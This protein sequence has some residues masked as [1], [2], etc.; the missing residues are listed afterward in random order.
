MRSTDF[1]D[2]VSGRRRGVAAA[3]ARAA[4]AVAEGPYRAAVWWRNRRYDRRPD[5]VHACGVPVVSV[6]N[7]TLG[8]SGKTPMVKW[9]ARRLRAEGVRVALV[10]RGY[11]AEGGG[12]NDE[13]LELE[14]SLPDVP[15][16]QNR[17]RVEAARVA[18][19]ELAAQVVVMDDGFQHRRLARDLDLVLLD[20]TQPFGFGRVFPRGALREPVAGL[21]RAHAVCLT[22]AELVE[23]ATREAVRRRVERLAP[24]AVWCE[25]TTR[26]V[27]LVSAGGES[28]PLEGLRG[29][30]VA[31]FCGIGN[32][33]SFRRLL[34]GLGADVRA[35]LEF[36][37][38]H[39]YRRADVE[40]IERVAE[41]ADLVV[42]TQKDLVKVGVDELAGCPLRA[43]AIEAEL[44]VGEAGLSGLLGELARRAPTDPDEP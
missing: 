37:D 16:V 21:R 33:D 6:G 39:L 23:T 38:H 14:Q 41:G 42:C 12:P 40:R 17:D 2:L 10:S 7:L 36:P 32:P 30:G 11:G 4:L 28:E 43:V 5:L 8:G 20:A 27:A 35:L 24:A 19:E 34:A 26:P 29:G 31:A 44:A 15:H 22:R 3:A 18:V 9:V 1:Y 25:A 13:A